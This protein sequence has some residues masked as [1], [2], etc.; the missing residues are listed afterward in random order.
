MVSLRNEGVSWSPVSLGVDALTISPASIVYTRQ[1]QESWYCHEWKSC[2]QQN[3]RWAAGFKHLAKLDRG[4]TWYPKPKALPEILCWHWIQALGWQRTDVNFHT[5]TM[6][7]RISPESP[8]FFNSVRA[9]KTGSTH[10]PELW[11][12]LRALSRSKRLV[13]KSSGGDQHWGP[14]REQQWWY[15]RAPYPPNSITR[16]PVTGRMESCSEQANQL[17]RLEF[18][19]Q[20]QLPK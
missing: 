8:A 10:N 5:H 15:W 12:L 17:D 14:S 1:L 6:L 4:M 7:S 16:E 9:T 20:E 13:W 19:L 18:M 11:E 3:F 2:L